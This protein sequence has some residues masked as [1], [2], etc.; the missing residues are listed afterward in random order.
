[1]VAA[2]VALCMQVD[3]LRL[4]SWRLQGG[5]AAVIVAVASLLVDD[6]CVQKTGSHVCLYN[7]SMAVLKVHAA[8]HIRGCG[9]VD[10]QASLHHVPVLQSCGCVLRGR[11]ASD[12]RSAA[13]ALLWLLVKPAFG[14]LLGTAVIL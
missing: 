4:G 3:Q 12:P 5:V 11:Q 14:R 1:M 10:C 7:S 6:G 8:R 2:T 9:Y 13:S